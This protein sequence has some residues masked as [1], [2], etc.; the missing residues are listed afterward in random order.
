MSNS[1][2]KR[3]GSKNRAL[4][5]FWAGVS[6]DDMYQL[7]RQLGWI[8]NGPQSHMLFRFIVVSGYLLLL[9][10]WLAWSAE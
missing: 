5:G 8:S 4:L 1:M 2:L 10:T 6:A 9:L 7:A 3:Y